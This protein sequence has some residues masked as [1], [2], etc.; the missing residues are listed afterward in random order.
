MRMDETQ[1]VLDLIQDSV[2]ELNAV[3]YHPQEIE[4]ILNS[5]PESL[6]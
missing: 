4:T 5:T 3:D 1:M 6:E 2:R